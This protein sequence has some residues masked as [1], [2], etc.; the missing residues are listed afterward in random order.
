[1]SPNA[2]SDL[3]YHVHKR[4]NRFKFQSVVAASGLI[5][6][7]FAPVEGKR[8][9]C[10]SGMPADFGLLNQLQQ[11]SFDTGGRPLCIYGDPAYAV[12]I[13]LQTGFRG[14]N[15][16]REKELSESKMSSVRQGK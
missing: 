3:L 5:T 8:Q 10:D 4:Y 2:K 16:T 14:G 11:H 6:N 13:H 15:I 7:L 1:M 12:R 9:L